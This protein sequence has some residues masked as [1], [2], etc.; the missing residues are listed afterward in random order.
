MPISLRPHGHRS[1]SVQGD[2]II[3]EPGEYLF[4][5]YLPARVDEIVEK[6]FEVRLCCLLAV[7]CQRSKE[8]CE[9]GT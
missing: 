4:Q 3:G 5:A 7:C 2:G 1:F 9:A 8:A 6:S